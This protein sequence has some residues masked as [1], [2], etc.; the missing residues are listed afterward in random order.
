M[1]E[2]KPNVYEELFMDESKIYERLR[3]NRRLEDL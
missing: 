3:W 2:S 1:F